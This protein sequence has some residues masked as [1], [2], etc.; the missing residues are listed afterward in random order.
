MSFIGKSKIL[1]K[2]DKSTYL[3]L[4]GNRV[5]LLFTASFAAQETQRMAKTIGV[6]WKLYCTYWPQSPEQIE[7]IHRTL[8]VSFTRLTMETAGDWVALL[9]F[10]LHRVRSMPY[11]LELTSPLRWCPPPMIPKFKSDI[12]TEVTARYI[13]N[14]LSVIAYIQKV[15]GPHLRAT[16]SS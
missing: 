7:R 13:F 15:F 12:M 6:D 2:V 14:S 1:G 10:T 16:S 3:N 9:P 5:V 11:A 8:L 4:H